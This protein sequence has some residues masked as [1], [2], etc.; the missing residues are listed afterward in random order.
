LYYGFGL[1]GQYLKTEHKGS[2]IIFC[3]QT[4]GGVLITSKKTGCLRFRF[5][6]FGDVLLNSFSAAREK[7]MEIIR[8]QSCASLKNNTFKENE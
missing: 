8:I 6:L 3:F 1:T 7:D 2:N 5:L 4:K